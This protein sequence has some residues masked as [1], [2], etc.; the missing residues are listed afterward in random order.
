MIL[1]DNLYIFR[2][3][4]IQIYGLF[5]ISPCYGDISLPCFQLLLDVLIIYDWST[6]SIIPLQ[7]LFWVFFFVKWFTTLNA[8]NRYLL[9]SVRLGFLHNKKTLYHFLLGMVL[10]G[11]LLDQSS[12]ALHYSFVYA[13][14]F[15]AFAQW[16]R[17]FAVDGRNL[18]NPKSIYAIM[19]WC[20]PIWYFLECSS[21]WVKVCVRLEVFFKCMHYFFRFIRSFFRFIRSFFVFPISIIDSKIILLPLKPYFYLFLCI[22]HRIVG[23][24]YQPL[25]SG[26]IW[27]KVNF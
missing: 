6:T 24:I 21:L 5:E 13:K 23:T 4:V 3:S 20:F 10:L 14:F 27:H 11:G 9:W 25:R 2:H 22:L 8:S 7:Q 1:S 16:L 15:G 18:S 12:F 19:I 26:R 17:L